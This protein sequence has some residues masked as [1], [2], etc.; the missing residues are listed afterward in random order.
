MEMITHA[1][2]MGATI[3]QPLWFQEKPTFAAKFLHPVA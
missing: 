1:Q 3:Y 2:P